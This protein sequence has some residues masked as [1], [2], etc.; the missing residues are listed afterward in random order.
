MEHA[1]GPLGHPRE[2]ETESD[3]TVARA[4]SGRFKGGQGKPVVRWLDRGKRDHPTN[5]G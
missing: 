3:R 2:R 4:C 1:I 5:L